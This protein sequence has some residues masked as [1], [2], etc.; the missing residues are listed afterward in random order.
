MAFCKNCGAQINDVDMFCGVCGAPVERNEIPAAPVYQPAAVPDPAQYLDPYQAPYQAPVQN[1]GTAPEP[2]KRSNKGLIIG[3]IAG[4]ASLLVVIAICVSAVLFINKAK[5]EIEETTERT[6]RTT[7]ETTDETTEETT[8]WTTEE[9]TEETTD[10]TTGETSET[11][12]NNGE[13][14]LEDVLD[15]AIL[16]SE[17]DKLKETSTFKDAYKDATVEIRGNDIIYKYYYNKSMTAD[18]IKRVRQALEQS[19]LK[20][21][22]EVLKDS[23][24]RACGIRPTS[25]IYT[26]YTADD[27]EIASIGG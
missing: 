14:T 20:S 26:Y 21:T 16:Q 25:I 4:G 23:V 11:S 2:P 19:D 5:R 18:Q 12:R 7:E 15:R 8:E 3:L 27:V 1:Y 17:I 10:E 9:T 24:E 6:R 22:I 13:R